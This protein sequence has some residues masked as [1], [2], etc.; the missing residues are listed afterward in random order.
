M[1]YWWASYADNTR[2]KMLGPWI[3]D[4]DVTPFNAWKK[5]RKDC[6]FI[7]FPSNTYDERTALQEA[8][9]IWNTPELREN[10]LLPSV[11]ANLSKSMTEESIAASTYRQRKTTADPIT[12]KLY[13]HIAGEEDTHRTEFNKRFSELESDNAKIKYNALGGYI[14]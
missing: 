2:I 9:H 11:K 8:T 3:H 1:K 4:D 10:F 12:A 5:I 13:E 6:E 7:V 14:A